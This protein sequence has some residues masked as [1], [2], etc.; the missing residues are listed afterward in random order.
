MALGVVVIPRETFEAFEQGKKSQSLFGQNIP[1]DVESG[2]RRALVALTTKV[3]TPPSRGKNLMGFAMLSGLSFL[4]IA[5]L[6][7]AILGGARA[8]VGLL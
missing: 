8:L 5:V 3:Q 6:A 4:E 2:P 7:I 1:M